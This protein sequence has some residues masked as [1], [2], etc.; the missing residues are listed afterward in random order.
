MTALVK[1]RVDGRTGWA[2]ER[3]GELFGLPDGL[4]AL[5]AL[6]V[7]DIRSRLEH[8]SSRLPRSAR[9]CCPVESQEVW[10]AGV[11]YRRSRDGRTEES[12]FSD[13]Y[14]DVYGAS[15]PEVFFK[16]TASRV[17]GEG[18]AVGIRADSD[19]DVPEP[20]LG[21]V[22]TAGGG[23]A[24]YVGGNGKSSRGNEG[25]NP[26][27]LPQAKVYSRSCAI[28]SRIVPAWEVDTTDLT[29]RLC[30][31]RG[32][33]VAFEAT[34]ST[35]AM[36]RQLPELVDWLMCA[37]DFPVGVF[38]LTGTGIVPPPEF[39]LR[40]GDV[41]TVSIDGVGTLTNPVVRVGRRTAVP[42]A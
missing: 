40:S 29:I 14:G 39:T 7:P 11:T 4:D 9:L 33:D 22:V 30:I 5:L 36:R 12:R 28:G 35:S 23:I 42:T 17:V 1:V 32:S 27:Y 15:R 26:L 18:E 10:A 24:G 2:V 20:E 13:A 41:V 19:W 37:L 31:R 25:A 16:A 38:L 21:L 3:D 6:P 8:A 34:T